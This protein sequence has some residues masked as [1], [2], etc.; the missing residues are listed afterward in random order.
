[1]MPAQDEKGSLVLEPG[2]ADLH[3][4]IATNLSLEEKRGKTTI[5]SWTDGRT[6]I[7]YTFEIRQ[8]GTF[9]LQADIAGEKETGI[10]LQLGDQPRTNVELSPSGDFDKFQIAD[11]GTLTIEEAGTYT[12]EIRPVSELWAP[13]N[14]RNISFEPV[15]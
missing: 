6:W 8:P 1:M 15:N 3:N 5:G 11:L 10:T 14:L 4:R 12:L 13:V 2:Y 7:S 9:K